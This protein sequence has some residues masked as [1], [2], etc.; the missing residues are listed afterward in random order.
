MDFTLKKYEELC[1]KIAKSNYRV[2]S[3][4]DYFTGKPKK[5]VILRHD[6]DKSP[7][8][9]LKMALIESKYDLKS[10]FYFRIK[11]LDLEVMKKISDMG[12]EIGYH[13]ECLD[14]T[15]GDYGKAIKIFKKN[16]DRFNN[17]DIKT[18]CM[19]GNALSKWNNRY[20]WKK[21]DFRKFGILGEAYI[22]VDFSELEYFSDTGRTW[23]PS[24]YNIKDIPEGYKPKIEINSTGDLK[25]LVSEGEKNLYIL[26]H[27]NRWSGSVF[28]WL[29]HL[30]A[31][32]IK[33]VGK[34][35]LKWGYNGNNK[36]GK[37]K[38]VE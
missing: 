20:L 9:A 34:S 30:I 11:T 3:L 21:Y 25:N 29:K 36:R 31:Q 35:F 18:I 19:H 1:Q 2:I 14:E 28:A 13:Y 32:S 8:N 4:K 10:T 7:K 12:H 16:L 26:T 22:S 24:K 23:D 38:R 33:N 6:V 27:P 17:F 37:G 5:F 15:K